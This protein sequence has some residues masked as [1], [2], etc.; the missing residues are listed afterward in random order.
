MRRL[1]PFESIEGL[2]GT[3]KSTIAPMLADARGAV[4]VPTVPHF[5]QPL[6]REL[7]AGANVNARMCFFLSALFTAA[8]QIR[9]YLDA[10][11]PVVVESYFARCLSTHRVYG[12][13]VDVI[14]PRDLPC[15][16]SY[17]LVCEPHERRKRLAGRA[18][19]TTRWDTLAEQN[20]DRLAAAHH[21]FPAHRIETTARH[22]ER[23]VEAILDLNAIGAEHA[24]R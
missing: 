9:R 10:G 7:D 12:A 3:G 13:D 15:P 17:Q 11:V 14:L 24:Q 2:P 4:L 5:Y 22:P 19:P 16:V 23:I 8:D 21:E 18:R 20:A 6:R 1:L